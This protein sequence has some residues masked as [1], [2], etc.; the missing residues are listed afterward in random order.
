MKLSPKQSALTDLQ[1][2][3]GIGKS[4]AEDLF[5]IGIRSV[6]D[7]K[8]RDPQ[9]LYFRSCAKVGCM[10]DRCLLYTYRCAVYFS[11]KKRAVLGNS[12]GPVGWEKTRRLLRD[13]N[14][15]AFA[16]IPLHTGDSDP[17]LADLHDQVLA[18]DSS[19]LQLDQH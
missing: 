7:L 2:I 11:S 18:T 8:G 16:V 4:I 6:N 13:F 17:N 12:K 9:E 1:R 3:P 15:S 14:L 5:E 10:I 19:G